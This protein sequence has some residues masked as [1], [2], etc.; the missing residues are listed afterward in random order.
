MSADKM[1]L[2]LDEFDAAGLLYEYSIGA[3]GFR[4]ADRTDATWEWIGFALTDARAL[5]HQGDDG[6]AGRRARLP[7]RQ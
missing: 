3:D 5:L 2:S 6:T 7:A 4:S 1:T